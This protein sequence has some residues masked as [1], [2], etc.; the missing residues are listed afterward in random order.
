MGAVGTQCE[1]RAEEGGLWGS[2][3]GPRAL[4]ELVCLCHKCPEVTTEG[5]RV[6]LA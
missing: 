5:S 2:G 3:V 6:V 1:S 4:G